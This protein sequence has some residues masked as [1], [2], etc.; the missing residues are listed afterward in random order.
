MAKR[1][2]DWTESKFEKYIKEGRGQGEGAN[3]KPWITIQDFPSR[4]LSTRVAGWKTN[5]I[6]HFL[7]KLERDFYYLCEWNLNIIDIREQFPLYRE[8]T[9]KLADEKGLK[10]PVDPKSNVPIVMTTDFLLTVKT[11]EGIKNV[12]RTIKPSID[13]ERFRVLEKFEIERHYWSQR[14][15]DWGIITEKEIP[16]GLV[17]NIEWLH[18]AY[19][20][21]EQFSSSSYAALASELK[22]V[23]QTKE[24]SIV[25]ILT[26]FERKWG[27]EN[28][29]ALTLFQYLIC[30][31][32]IVVDM[33][34]PLRLEKWAE[35]VIIR[36]ESLAEG[37]V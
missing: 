11:D 15:V 21:D 18:S 19:N 23:L 31:R 10:H 35:E 27:L 26:A 13:L 5:R 1:K 14:N 32:E 24:V 25:E 7:S 37:A 20:F 30:N 3:Y 33:E 29:L 22:H 16:K 8:D 34:V 12:A 9:L 6:H 2:T 36:I 17:T 4:G 28:G